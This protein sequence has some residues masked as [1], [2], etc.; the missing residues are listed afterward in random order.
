MSKPIKRIS[1]LILLYIL[2][3]AGNFI[4]G[5]AFIAAQENDFSDNDAGDSVIE[6]ETETAAV[7]SDIK[8]RG[9][10]FSAS[11]LFKGVVNPGWE[12]H[13]WKLKG[14][15]EFSWAFGTEMN[16]SMDI[17]AQ[18]SENFRVK[19][20]ISYG[21]PDFILTIGDFYFDYNLFNK[22]FLRTGKYEHSWGVSPNFSFTNL[23]SRIAI[24]K[25]TLDPQA[26]HYD[27]D[28]PSTD[29][30]SYMIK[31]DIPIGITNIQLLALTRVNLATGD[32]PT[33]DYIGY[34]GKLNLSYNWADF[35]IGIFYQSYMA[36][37][38][39]F[40][41][42]TNL[43]NTDIYSEW[44]IGVNNHTDNS[45]KFAANLGF[46]KN[47]FNDKLQINA[48]YFYNGEESTG[49]FSPE[50]ELR[51]EE[52]L[53][54]IEGHNAALNIQ[55]KFDGKINPRIFTDI[56]YGDESF[57]LLFGARINLFPNIEIYLA[58]PMALGGGYYYKN[59]TNYIS[60]NRPFS[61]LLYI[62]FNGSVRASY[63]Y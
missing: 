45:V 29:G 21:I 52:T 3:C 63:Y 34:G 17:A 47:F 6:E 36:T 57:K 20:V 27:K 16:A 26:P 8:K 46:S 41:V 53:P 9:I 33:N 18:I 50:S 62:N 13:P 12:V 58:V 42:K 19:S 39:F 59:L 5:Y 15:E 28:A 23:L 25:N 7:V 51:K 56:L 60:E 32:V 54:F 4:T 35:N 61:V 55:Y 24:Q 14:G 1:I 31:F 40:S 11:Y 22:V 37:R 2:L 30:T 10:E 44:L 49:Y 43:F 48:E 38:S